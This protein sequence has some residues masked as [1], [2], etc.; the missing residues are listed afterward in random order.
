MEETRKDVCELVIPD[1]ACRSSVVNRDNNIYIYILLYL[2]TYIYAYIY[3]SYSS[4][5][6][7][8]SRYTTV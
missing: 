6:L 1:P 3:T 5:P 4:K 8:L 7:I 2:Y